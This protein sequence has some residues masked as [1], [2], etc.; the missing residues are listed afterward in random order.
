MAATA[1]SCRCS[2]EPNAQLPRLAFQVDVVHAGNDPQVPVPDFLPCDRRCCNIDAPG[3]FNP[4]VLL[5]KDISPAYLCSL[6]PESTGR[7]LYALQLHHYAV[8]A[9]ATISYSQS[10]S[11]RGQQGLVTMCICNKKKKERKKENVLATVAKAVNARPRAVLPETK[12]CGPF[13]LC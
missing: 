6:V 2:R 10:C 4:M 8:T 7:N 1:I 9:T 13:P 11:Y 3:G 12:H 5:R